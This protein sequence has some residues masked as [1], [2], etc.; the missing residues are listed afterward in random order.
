MQEILIKHIMYHDELMVVIELNVKV[1]PAEGVDYEF[2]HFES[3]KFI[4]F[5]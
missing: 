3:N 5:D 2:L 4:E 1:L